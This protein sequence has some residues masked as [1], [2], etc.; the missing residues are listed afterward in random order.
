M[1]AYVAGVHT[2]MGKV[3]SEL[4]EGDAGMEEEDKGSQEGREGWYIF[5]TNNRL[6]VLGSD[7]A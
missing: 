4:F 3:A 1:C 5:S 7:S 2:G 6:P